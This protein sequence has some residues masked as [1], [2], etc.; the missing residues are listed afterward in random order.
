MPNPPRKHHFVQAAHIE[1]FINAGGTLSVYSKNGEDFPGTPKSIFKKRD[2]NSFVSPDGL[3]TS[4][5]NFVTKRENISFPA[6]KRISLKREI[7]L[8]DLPLVIAYLSLSLI[9]NPTVQIGVVELH[10]LCAVAS[11]KIMDKNGMFGIP[12]ESLG[13]GKSMADLIDEGILDF[14]INNIV[15]LK[16]FSEMIEAVFR[17]LIGGFKWSLLQ[18]PSGNVAISDH[19]LTFLTP[20]MDYRAYGIPMGGQNCEIAFPISKHLYLIGRWG[21]PFQNSDSELAV[22]QLNMRQAV[23]ANRQVASSEPNSIIKGLVSNYCAI[24]FQSKANGIEMGDG[25]PIMLRR[26][27]FPLTQCS[28]VNCY[29][30]MREVVPLSRLL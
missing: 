13:Q 2:L 9:R 27:V 10:R 5:E 28:T 24:G 20:G 1:Q 17:V 6:I 25:T 26:G 3:D 16:Y 14:D 18:S 11:A 19:P 7:S 21:D 30:F 23:F 8:E 29:E 4:F 12:P 15:Y 22:E